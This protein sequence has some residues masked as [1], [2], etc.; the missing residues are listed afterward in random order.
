M[1]GRI[2]VHRRTVEQVEEA[3]PETDSE[4]E[5]LNAATDEL[6]YKYISKRINNC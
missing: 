2:T 1:N 4:S 5:R 3:E 6:D